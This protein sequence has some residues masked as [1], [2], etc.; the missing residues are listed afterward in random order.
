MPTEQR[1]LCDEM[2]K[3]LGKWLRAAG[4]DTSIAAPGENDRELLASAIREKR[5]L[6]TRDRSFL[7]RKG[8][9]GVVFLL[10]ECGLESWVAALTSTL[11]I[12]WL[13]APFTRCLICN[14]PLEPGPGPH[15]GP[16]SNQLPAYVLAESV[17]CFHCPAC[18]RAF[19]RG[20]HVQRM[21]HRLEG[22]QASQLDGR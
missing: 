7:Q 13:H 5:L 1:F 18:A 21:R 14:H 17:P 8:S 9:E 2:L 15:A 22:W 16:Y 10:E 4:Y 11:A 20:G 6:I 3:G 19:W 12:D